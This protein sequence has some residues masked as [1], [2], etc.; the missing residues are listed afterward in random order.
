MPEQREH[1]EFAP[2]FAPDAGCERTNVSLEAHS[3][4]RTPCVDCAGPITIYAPEDGGRPWRCGRC[5]GT[6]LATPAEALEISNDVT[7]VINERMK[8]RADEASRRRE[9]LAQQRQHF[10]AARKVGLQHR[11]ANKGGMRR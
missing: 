8:Q 11:H 4:V 1:P 10:A 9:A 3:F 6:A 2:N 7:E 5:A